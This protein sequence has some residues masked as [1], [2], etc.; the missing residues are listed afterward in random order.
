MDNTLLVA[1]KAAKKLDV[2]KTL[3]ASISL[4]FSNYLNILLTVLL[5]CVTVWIPYLNVGTTIAISSLPAELAKGNK[6]NP[7]FIF[8][9]KYRKNIGE[10]F[11]LY[12][13]MFGA[14]L[15]GMFFMFVPGYVIAIAWC[16]AIILFVDQNKS[17]L[18]AIRE[19]NQYTY[20]NKWNIFFVIMIFSIALG[21]VTGVI[22]VFFGLISAL[23][24]APWLM[25]I[26]QIISMIISLAFVPFTLSANAVMYKELVLERESTDNQ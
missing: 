3:K 25:V 4:A 15:I 21:I 11:I 18:E 6:V 26:A 2:I 9:A 22:S 19:S 23:T 17:A 20:G 16:F 7:A 10:F 8:D 1:P 12:T 24:Y 14:I 13:L 5:Y